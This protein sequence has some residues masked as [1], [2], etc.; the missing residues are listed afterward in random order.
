VT[1]SQKNLWERGDIPE[2][3]FDQYDIVDG[4]IDDMEKYMIDFIRKSFSDIKDNLHI[5]SF[6]DAFIVMPSLQMC[7][8]DDIDVIDMNIDI[9]TYSEYTQE[10]ELN[11]ENVEDDSMDENIEEY[12]QNDDDDDDDDDVPIGVNFWNSKYVE[13]VY[14]D[15]HDEEEIELDD[16]SNEFNLINNDDDYYKKIEDNYVESINNFYDENIADK[17]EVESYDNPTEDEISE[18]EM[19]IIRKS[20]L[21]DEDM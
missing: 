2:I 9:N 17:S 7:S 19:D 12:Q 20:L 8:D 18:M 14:Q 13:E 5:N 1:E 10:D 3:S 21:G 11:S 4:D 16:K 6:S 15:P